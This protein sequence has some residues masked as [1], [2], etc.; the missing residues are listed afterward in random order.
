MARCNAVQMSLLFSVAML[1]YGSSIQTG[2]EKCT[3]AWILVSLIFWVLKLDLSRAESTQK[4]HDVLF[5]FAKPHASKLDIFKWFQCH[6]LSTTQLISRRWVWTQSADNAVYE[7][8]EALDGSVKA[9]CW[10]HHH[11]RYG[12]T[13]ALLDRNHPITLLTNSPCGLFSSDVLC[14]STLTTYCCRYNGIVHFKQLIIEFWRCR[15]FPTQWI[16]LRFS[17]IVSEHFS[18]TSLS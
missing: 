11:L 8:Q 18:G 6:G 15:T 13:N 5:H 16:L 17:E 2:R 9:V 3:V 14:T 4:L 1:N 10:Q 7:D 12:A